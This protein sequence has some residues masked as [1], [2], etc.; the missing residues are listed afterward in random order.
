MQKIDFVITWVDG[1]DPKWQAEKAKYKENTYGT[2]RSFRYR[3]WDNLKYWFR[4]VENFAPWVN[5]IYFV[6]WGHIPTWLDTTNPK[7][8][9]VKH[10]EFIPKEY[11]PTFHS[12]TIDLNL[13]RIKG[14]SEQFVYFNDDMFL[15][16][17]VKET[18]FFKHGLPCDTAVQNAICFGYGD[19]A[20][21]KKIPTAL[22][23]TAPA[24][25]V[26]PINR[27][28]NKK[29][30][31]KR[32]WY[33]WYSPV[34]GK[35]CLRTLLLSPWNMYTGFMNYHL[36]YSYL[37]S[38]YEVVWEK[39]SEVLNET[40]MAKFRNS[41]QVNHWVFSYWQFASG[42]FIPRNPNVGK[43][44]RITS[45]SDNNIA[46]DAIREQKYKMIC[47]NDSVDDKD[48]EMI[49]NEINMCFESILPNKSNFEK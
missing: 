38:T 10:E 43:H 32:Y 31:M 4:G 21:G 9:V 17:P 8:V 11:L 12:R 34:Y 28:F 3:D 39:E 19:V 15:L 41:T 40:C 24:W 48:F 5:K 33:K 26:I 16:S 6:T 37:K 27:N 47:L 18:L 2:S 7:L 46:Y 30:M 35:Q 23:F 44:F 1:N 49:K 13:Y 14:L 20:G 45:N 42:N 25:D 22:Q 29:R 36:P